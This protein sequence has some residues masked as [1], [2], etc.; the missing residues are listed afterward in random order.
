V[1]G[2]LA[3]RP[4]PR[5][6]LVGGA[7]RH[8]GSQRRIS[9]PPALIAHPAD[10]KESTMHRHACILVDVHPRLQGQLF[11]SRNRSF[12]PKPRMNNLHSSH[13]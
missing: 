11:R 2:A 6:P 3:A 4:M 5:Q 13:N 9:N 10:Q 1:E 7:H 12:N 8:P